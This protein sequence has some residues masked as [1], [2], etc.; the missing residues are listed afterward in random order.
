MKREPSTILWTRILYF[1]ISGKMVTYFK[2]VILLGHIIIPTL[3]KLA[4]VCLIFGCD[5]LASVRQEAIIYRFEKCAVRQEACQNL[6][7]KRAKFEP[8]CCTLGNQTKCMHCWRTGQQKLI[9]FYLN[10][11]VSLTHDITGQ[12]YQ[13]ARD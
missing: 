4:F 1:T 12:S 2:E 5:F 6:Y 11:N 9:S 3:V 13:N 7:A 10:F 8:K